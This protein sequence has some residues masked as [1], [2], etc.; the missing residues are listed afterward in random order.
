MKDEQEK[1]EKSADATANETETSLP[2]TDPETV[3]ASDSGSTS[4][5]KSTKK[6]KPTVKK[7]TSKKPTG[8]KASKDCYVGFDLG[9]TKML[10]AVFDADMNEIGR[11]RRRTKAFDGP[12]HSLERIFDSVHK[13]LEKAEREVSDLRSIGLGCPGPLDLDK[14]I[15]KEAFNLRFFDVPLKQKL[16]DEFKCPAHIINDVDAG[17]YG[18]YRF[19]AAKDAHCVLGIFPGT[20]I[21][22]GCVY[23]GEL[24][25]GR[26]SS[27]MEIGHVPILPNGPLCVCGLRGCLEAVASRSA[28]AAAAGQAALRGQAPQ[29]MEDTGGDLSKIR[30]SALA[31]SIEAGDEFVRKLVISS[32]EYVG[33]AAANFVNLLSPDIVVLGGGLVEAIPDEYVKAAAKAARK[34][35]IPSL[36]DTFKVQAAEL[37]DDSTL[38]GAFAW[39]KYLTENA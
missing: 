15:V 39:G 27:C 38:L 13:A 21:G 37:G 16:E 34:N 28:I 35:T 7:P 12:E 29:L 25:R 2:S 32:A 8:K 20:G 17:V 23:K 10:A 22:G 18:E 26:V 5:S 4:K 33:I 19:G 24:L 14:G 11:K 3:P 6:K 36:R 9:G 31:R 1:L 30:S